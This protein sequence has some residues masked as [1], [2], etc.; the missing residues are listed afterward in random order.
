MAETP[1]P[2]ALVLAQRRELRT[3]RQWVL[4]CRFASLGFAAWYLEMIIVEGKDSPFYILVN[5][6]AVVTGVSGFVAFNY[7]D[8]PLLIR[9]LHAP[10]SPLRRASWAALHELRGELLPTMLQDLGITE[11][12]RAELVEHIELAD[13]VRRTAPTLRG[14]RKRFGRIYLA[15]YLPVAAAFIYLVATYRPGP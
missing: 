1:T 3:R 8:P 11:P 7:F 10:D 5:L 2:A 6:F 4:A 9:N 15:V 13:L 14:D 12:T